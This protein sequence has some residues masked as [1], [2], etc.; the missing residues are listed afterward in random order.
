VLKVFDRWGT[1]ALAVSTAVPFPFPT[2]VFF[3]AAGASGYDTR[4]YVSVVGL[5]RAARYFGIAILADRYGRH[6]VRV[7]RHPDRY[8][9]WLLLFAGIVG[10]LIAAATYINKRLETGAQT[11]QPTL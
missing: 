10:A 3:A 7:V 1:G 5:C 8:W 4:K 2:S 6:F 9:G 11:A